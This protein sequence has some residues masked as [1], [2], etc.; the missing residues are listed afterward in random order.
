MNIYKKYILATLPIVLLGTGILGYWSYSHSRDALY[1]TELEVLTLQL[2]DAV[3]QIVNRR[4]ELLKNTGL[5]GIASFVKRYKSEVFTDLRN[6]G[7]KTNRRIFIIDS[8]G[9]EIFC[10]DCNSSI[11]LKGWTDLATQMR[12]PT[13]G[14]HAAAENDNA[15]FAAAPFR[16]PNWNWVVFLTRQESEISTK[17]ASIAKF[18]LVIS[19]LSTVAVAV[20]L[21]GITRHLLVKPI[22]KLQQ[23]AS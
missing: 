3:N 8:N 6:L 5:S 19:L 2:D 20:I 16:N 23:A 22:L 7:H 1:R 13:S 18:A 15:I 14:T 4:F 9:E 17:V 11:P 21:A 12:R 10:S